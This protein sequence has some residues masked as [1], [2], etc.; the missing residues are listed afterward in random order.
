[1]EYYQVICRLDQSP[2]PRFFEAIEEL[3]SSNHNPTGTAVHLGKTYPSAT[4]MHIWLRFDPRLPPLFG[5]QLSEVCR[6]VLITDP[7][8]ADLPQVWGDLFAIA[9]AR[10]TDSGEMVQFRAG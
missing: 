7:A 10:E 3:V 8:P 2:P 4:V 6:L 9:P 5:R 1:M